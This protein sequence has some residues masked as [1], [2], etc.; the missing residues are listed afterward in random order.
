MRILILRPWFLKW[1][2]INNFFKDL[3]LLEYPTFISTDQHQP[4]MKN[5]AVILFL[6]ISITCH[7][8]N[9]TSEKRDIQ[10]LEQ[11]FSSK[12]EKEFMES[13][14]KDFSTLNATFGW[15]EELNKAEPLYENSYSYI[16]YWFSLL[17]KPQYMQYEKSI[18]A[19]SKNGKWDADA[20]NYFQKN[21]LEYIKRNNKYTLLNSLSEADLRS[22]LSFLLD[23]PHPKPD[24]VLISHLT[25]EKQIIAK[26]VLVKISSETAYYIHDS[27]GYT[28]L[29]KSPNTS[30]QVLQ[31]IKSGEQIEVLD[32]SGNWWFVVSKKRIKGYIHKS[33][34]ENK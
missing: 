4:I 3:F 26:E 8:Q 19:I 9:K 33:R 28:N 6:I 15:N 21:A 5:I 17:Q 25:P 22:V 11:S 27:D 34:I 23:S 12:Q 10:K 30:S 18:I 7:S 1:K 31:K 16:E 13:F 2:A 24:T 29:R 14:P 20:V 32:Q